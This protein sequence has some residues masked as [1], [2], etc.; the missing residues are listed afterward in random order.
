MSLTRRVL[1]DRPYSGDVGAIWPGG[2]TG[3]EARPAAYCELL[4]PEGPFVF[5]GEHLSYRPTWREG[6][7]LFAHEAPQIVHPVEAAKAP[8]TSRRARA[9]SW[10]CREQRP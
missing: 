1:R 8:V 9:G 5:A 3:V 10:P 4:R 7:L 2:A 6:A